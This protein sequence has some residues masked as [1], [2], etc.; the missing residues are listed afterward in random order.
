MKTPAYEAELYDLLKAYAARRERKA[1]ATYRPAAP[2]VYGLEQARKRLTVIARRLTD[3]ERLDSLLPDDAELGEDRPERASVMASS[4]LAALEI[5]KEGDTR[6]RQDGN[7]E[8]IWMRAAD[9]T[10][11]EGP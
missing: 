10:K 2:R 7:Y 3:W 5:T 8:P 9:K 6:L 4:L 11:R 1:F